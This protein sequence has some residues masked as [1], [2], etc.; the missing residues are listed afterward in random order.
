MTR[1]RFDRVHQHEAATLEAGERREFRRVLRGLAATDPRWFGSR[2][3]D[4]VRHGRLIRS[5][6]A[7]LAVVLLSA[8]ALTG[9]MLFVLGAVLIAVGVLTSHVSTRGK[10]R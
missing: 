9:N 7:A 8:G 10:H 4:R 1:N 6:L 5:V 2:C 3:P